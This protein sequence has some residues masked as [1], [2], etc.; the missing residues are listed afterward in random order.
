[1]DIVCLKTSAKV[2][3]QKFVLEISARISV[4]NYPFSTRSEL[5]PLVLNIY[6]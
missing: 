5:A 2:I 3:K 1:M 6:I 4:K